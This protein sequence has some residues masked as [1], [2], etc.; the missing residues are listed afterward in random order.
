LLVHYK[1]YIRG[2]LLDA[3]CGEKPYSLLYERLVE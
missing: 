3:G 2:K 1:R